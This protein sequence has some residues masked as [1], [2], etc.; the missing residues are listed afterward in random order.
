MDLIYKVHQDQT[1][2]RQ[3]SITNRKLIPFNKVKAHGGG[4]L[5]V[6][7]MWY[8]YSLEIFFVCHMAFNKLNHNMDFISRLTSTGKK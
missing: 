7:Q 2:C 5:R 1:Y 8:V 4:N 6:V 3:K